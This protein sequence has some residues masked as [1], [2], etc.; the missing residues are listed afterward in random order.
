MGWAQGARPRRS[1]AHHCQWRGE[2][3]STD[4]CRVIL[5]L[6]DELTLQHRCQQRCC[7]SEQAHQHNDPADEE[8]L[9]VRRSFLSRVL[10]KSR[11][12]QR[13]QPS[14]P[15]MRLRR[16]QLCVPA[17]L[18]RTTRAVIPSMTTCRPPHP[19]PGQPRQTWPFRRCRRASQRCVS[20]NIHDFSQCLVGAC[21][22]GAAAAVFFPS[23]TCEELICSASGIFG[24]LASPSTDGADLL[25]MMCC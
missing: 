14:P 18:L 10:T 16:R 4:N 9:A 17:A 23:H 13:M 20:T 22:V 25:L 12:V 3:P 5:A 6:H 19:S 1:F 7:N 11:R 15:S 21:L 2:A 24:F 8:L